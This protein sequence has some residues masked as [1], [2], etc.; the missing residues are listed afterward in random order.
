MCLLLVILSEGSLW[1][2]NLE[3]QKYGKFYRPEQVGARLLGIVEKYN[4]WK[5][6]IT[7]AEPVLGKNSFNHLIEV[8]DYIFARRP[9]LNFILETNGFILGYNPRFIYKLRFPNLFVRVNIK[10]WDEESFER[11][12]GAKKEFFPYPVTAVKNMLDVGISSWVAIWL[13]CLEQ[14]GG[15]N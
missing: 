13:I 6:R 12:T 8:I 3:P 11:I 9:D 10:G 15:K 5:V 7:G 14:R 1:D 4:L 2:K